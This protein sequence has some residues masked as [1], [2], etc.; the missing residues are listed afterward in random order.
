MTMTRFGFTLDCLP[1]T[2]YKQCTRM[3]R[4]LSPTLS[5][6]QEFILRLV[7]L[8]LNMPM[9]D[10]AYRFRISLST[11]SRIFWA[12]MV[13]LSVR[14]APLLG[15]PERE[16]LW[17]TMPRCFQAIFG[18]RITVIIDCFEVFISRPFASH[19]PGTNF[20]HLQVSQ[21]G[22]N[23]GLNNSTREYFILL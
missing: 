6:F 19:G 17:R 9:Q 3:F 16:D 10:L 21:Y 23:S 12:G 22:Q 4:H 5:K 20:L 8:K 1:M 7:K 11:V 18:N 2:C 15:W 13:V 14:L